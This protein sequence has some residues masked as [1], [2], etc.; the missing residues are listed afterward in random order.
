MNQTK[1]ELFAKCKEL[2]LKNYKSKNKNQLVEL[3]NGK[4]I[5]SIFHKIYKIRMV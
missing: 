5:V 4:L 3:L 2:G 1:Q